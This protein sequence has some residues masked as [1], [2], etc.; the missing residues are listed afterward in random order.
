MGGQRILGVDPSGD[1]W[2]KTPT[3]QWSRVNVSP[4][5]LKFI[6]VSMTSFGILAVSN[7]NELYI[8]SLTLPLTATLTT[9]TWSKAPNTTGGYIAAVTT[10]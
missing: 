8:S 10:A 3:T 5:G 2:T 1:L 9:T 7:N 4:T 6:Y